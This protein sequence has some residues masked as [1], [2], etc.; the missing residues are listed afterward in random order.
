MMVCSSVESRVI[1]QR[2]TSVKAEQHLLQSA[3]KLRRL[4]PDWAKPTLFIDKN[5]NNNDVSVEVTL[6]SV[7][8]RQHTSTSSRD[9]DVVPD[10]QRL[11]FFRQFPPRRRPSLIWRLTESDEGHLKG[12][13]GGGFLGL[14][15][16]PVAGWWADGHASVVDLH[17]SSRRWR[18]AV[19]C[20]IV[21]CF[22]VG[23]L[24]TLVA[25][26]LRRRKRVRMTTPKL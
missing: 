20:A 11:D 17:S 2:C 5:N 15:P 25:V 19:M 18:T 26:W 13:I 24:L 7:N 6:S 22:V 16:R 23:L 3:K 1:V 9:L 4:K 12:S 21:I 10:V 8:E 14:L